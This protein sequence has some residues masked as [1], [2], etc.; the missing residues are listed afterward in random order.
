MSKQARTQDKHQAAQQGDFAAG[1]YFEADEVQKPYA[2]TKDEKEDEVPG[3]INSP[4]VLFHQPFHASQDDIRKASVIPL[5]RMINQPAIT[6]KNIIEE[7]LP[8]PFMNW[9]IPVDPVVPQNEDADNKKS[10]EEQADGNPLAGHGFPGILTNADL[11]CH[12]ALWY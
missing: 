3:K 5:V 12:S 9:L 10:E 6:A 2:Q 8:F 7:S 11:Q 1:K 4:R